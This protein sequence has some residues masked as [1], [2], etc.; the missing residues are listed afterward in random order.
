MFKKYENRKSLI[1]NETRYDLG[2]AD[3]KDDDKINSTYGLSIIANGLNPY[4][5]NTQYIICYSF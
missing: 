4:F 2:N 3:S 1:R 5:L